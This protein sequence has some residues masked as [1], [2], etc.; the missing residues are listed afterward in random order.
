[1]SVPKWFE[2]LSACNGAGCEAAKSGAL[3]DDFCDTCQDVVV[4]DSCYE[5][6]VVWHRADLSFFPDAI[7]PGNSSYVTIERQHGTKRSKIYCYNEGWDQ[8][9]E[10]ELDE[11]Q[12]Q[13]IQLQYVERLLK[14]E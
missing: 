13:L 2:V 8:G 4:D 6:H 11:V 12:Y 14:G 9:T 7:H 3:G 5:R 1:M 10:V